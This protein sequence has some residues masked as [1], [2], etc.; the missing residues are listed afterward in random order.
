[1]LGA[2]VLTA[3]LM[4]G[5]IASTSPAVGPRHLVATAAALD[6]HVDRRIE[7]FSVLERL[8]GRAEYGLATTPYALAA[9]EW[10]APFRDEPAVRMLRDLIATNGIGYDAAMTLAVHVD[11]QFRPIAPLDP[12]PDAVDRRWEGVDLVHLLDDV[13]AFV[14]TS[15]FDDFM[16]EHDDYIAAVEAEFGSFLRSRPIVAWFDG[17]F[18]ARPHDRYTVVPGLLVGQMSYGVHNDDDGAVYA[19][20]SLESADVDGIPSPGL[21][22]EEYLVHEFAHSYVNPV[23]RSS[24]AVFGGEAP[25][26]DAAV[27]AMAQQAYATREVVVAESIVRALTV[28]YLRD[29]VSADAANT[30][31]QVQTGLGFVWTADLARALDRSIQAGDG[32]L[33]DQVLVDTAAG[34]L[35]AR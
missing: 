19:I 8:A 14:A 4:L 1:M 35:L 34:V 9:D 23:V 2:I 5:G 30:S 18:G 27:P 28:L 13:A 32:L 21:L 15:R 3:A 26:L 24:L 10:F 29:E 11:E 17:V 7:L 31:L 12:R 20:M 33:T 22:T 25:L 16:G 6:V